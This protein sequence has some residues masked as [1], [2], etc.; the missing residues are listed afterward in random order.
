MNVLLETAR[1]FAR[2]RLFLPACP[3]CSSL[4]S[5][6]FKR[7]SFHYGKNAMRYGLAACSFGCELFDEMPTG[8]VSLLKHRREMGE[9]API[10]RQTRHKAAQAILARRWRKVVKGF[11]FPYWTEARIDGWRNS[12]GGA[13]L[14][15]FTGEALAPVISGE[16]PIPASVPPV[17]RQAVTT[18]SNTQ[19]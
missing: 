13:W 11:K 16:N 10:V 17:E 7:P 5:G 2:D 1:L 3:A 14:Q 4:V 18:P 12:P 19:P 8:W 6:D 15:D 9:E